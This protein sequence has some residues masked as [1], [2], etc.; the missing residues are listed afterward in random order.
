M[1]PER[2]ESV[3]LVSESE[4][5]EPFFTGHHD[6]TNFSLKKSL[7]STFSIP[8]FLHHFPVLRW[9]RQYSMEDFQGDLV[10]GVTVG[11]TVIPQGMAYATVAG[12]ATNYGLYS[13]FMGC[14]VY[15]VLGSSKD[16]TI[17]PTAIMALMTQQFTR[18][19]PCLDQDGVV[20]NMAV[21]LTFI[22]GIVILLATVFRIGFL[23]NFIGRPVISGFTSAAAV[24][25]GT[26]Q[27]KSLLGIKIH[28]EGFVDTWKETFKHIGETRWQDFSLGLAC[29]VLLL[30]MKYMRDFAIV[31]PKPSDDTTARVI[32]KIIFIS[33]AGRNALVV[34]GC[35][36][37]SALV[38][39]IKDNTPLSIVGHIED[40]MPSP[41]L[42]HFTMSCNGTGPNGT[43]VQYGFGEVIG[44]FGI[45]AAIVPLLAILEDIAIASAFSGGKAIDANQEMLA[46]GFCNLLGAFFLSIPTTGSFSRTAVNS[47]SGVRTP[48]GGVFTGAVVILALL[49]L[50]PVFGYIPK[51]SLA[52]VI[53]CAVIFMV[54]Y[55]D[56]VP[57]WKTC[58]WDQLPLWTTFLICL[59][60]GLEYGILCGA[61]IHICI[62]LY[63]S[64]TPTVSVRFAGPHTQ[65][66][67]QPA[68]GFL[69]PN[70]ETIKEAA[71]RAGLVH[72]SC[73]L[74]IDCAHITQLDFTSA[75]SIKHL[76]AEYSSRGQPMA[77]ANLPPRVR[78]GLEALI[79]D[80]KEVSLDHET[81]AGCQNCAGVK[82][83]EAKDAEKGEGQNSSPRLCDSPTEST[84]VLSKE[85]V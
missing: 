18:D 45:G 52:A 14:F 49:F 76:V 82:A 75:T 62:L 77:F 84:A 85:K 68:F 41:S 66:V 64:A 27:I 22:T 73:T 38:Q 56:V 21:L 16:I 12:V 37:V 3:G 20:E 4:L 83:L 6:V 47:T 65:L 29:I 23:I 10:A 44:M 74:V 5:P 39:D 55:H 81:N 17:G 19:I 36:C 28:A 72:V 33:S 2:T 43:D 32:K 57:M 61:G 26:T 53:I 24:T 40:G 11:L 69:F 46:L 7:A 30:F 54:E 1:N 70:A 79:P 59:F 71:A 13:A 48:G 78:K 58:W 35:C 8:N 25:I 67:V 31:K 60:W 63:L 51:S 42:P 15:M 34:L 9:G 80:L 50:T